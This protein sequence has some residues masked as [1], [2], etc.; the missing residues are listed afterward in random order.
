LVDFG[1]DNFMK[2]IDDFLKV[3]LGVMNINRLDFL[4]KNCLKRLFPLIN[5]LN[6]VNGENAQM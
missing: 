2:V 6:T 1:V 3:R 4:L 5:A